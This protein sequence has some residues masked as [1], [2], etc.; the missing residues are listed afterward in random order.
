MRTEGGGED[1]NDRNMLGT[2]VIDVLLA[3]D[4]AACIFKSISFS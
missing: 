3:F 4:F 2:E 1:A